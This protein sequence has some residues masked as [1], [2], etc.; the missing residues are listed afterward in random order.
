VKDL[1]PYF[2]NEQTIKWGCDY[3]QMMHDVYRGYEA[4]GSDEAR[5]NYL[6]TRLL[7]AWRYHDQTARLVAKVYDLESGLDYTNQP[8]QVRWAKMHAKAMLDLVKS[9]K[10]ADR[11]FGREQD[12]M[13]E[14]KVGRTLYD[15]VRASYTNLLYSETEKVR[16]KYGEN[17]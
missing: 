3:A 5:V 9:K 14:V 16:L 13:E 12:A 8:K 11:A 6:T 4:F 1:Y 17:V 7:E 15:P 10:L 2:N